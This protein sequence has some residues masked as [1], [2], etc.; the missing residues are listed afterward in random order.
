MTA[1]PALGLVGCGITAALMGVA[2]DA[3]QLTI[4]WTIQALLQG[5]G[6]PT[7]SVL[8]L[9]R[10]KPSQL[11]WYWGLISLA[12]NVGASVAP[13]AMALLCEYYEEQ[14]WKA[15]FFAG[16]AV[17]VLIGLAVDLVLQMGTATP[18]LV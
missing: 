12:G 15:I 1:I 14:G 16:G 3:S 13:I 9:D 17:A 7:A 11:G 10:V 2:K 18:L 8:L 4:L 5:L 6:W